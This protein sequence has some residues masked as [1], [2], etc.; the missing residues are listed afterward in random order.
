ML[1]IL[2]KYNLKSKIIEDVVLAPYTSFKI[3]GKADLFIIPYSW[4][5]FLLIITLLKEFNIPVR[6]LGQGTNIL[7][8][9]EGIRGAVIKFGQNL[10][11]INLLDKERLEVEAGCLVSRLISYMLERN[12]GGLEFMIGIPGTLGGA[13]IGNAGAWNKSIGEF[14]EEVEILDENLKEKILKKGDL[15]FSYRDSNIRRDWIIKRVI[16][17]V[18]EKPKEF[19]LKEIKNYLKERNKKI[20]KYPSAGSI[21]K[22]P[23]EGPA[24]YFIDSLGLKGKRIGDAMISYEHA[25]IIVNLG[26]ARSTDVMELIEYV[27][28]KVREAYNINLEPEIVFW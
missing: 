28:L 17:K 9:D 24:G 3:G 10:G 2:S 5:E 26:K 19:S 22:N 18:K 11:R 27:R 20:P 21:F 1:N 8:P 4:S 7:I 15:V 25:N 23:K 13:V 6:I 12:L 14:V 16:L